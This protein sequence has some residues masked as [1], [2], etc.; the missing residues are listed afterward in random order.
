MANYGLRRWQIIPL[1]L[2]VSLEDVCVFW[3]ILMGMENTKNR[4]FFS[5][6]LNYPAG[7]MSWRSGVIVAAAPDLI[8]AQDTTGDGKADL[9]EVLYSGF[10][11]GNQQLRVNGLSWGLDNWIHGANGSHHPGY[12]KNTMIHSSRAGSTLPLGSMDFRIRPD[13]GLMEALS[14]PSAIWPS[15]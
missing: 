10:K 13:E 2:M 15:A 6:G 5:K 12:A 7:I 14:G 3:R 4:L 11:Q 9:Q 1:E 8:Y